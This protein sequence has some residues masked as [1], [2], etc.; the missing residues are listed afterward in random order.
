MRR[1]VLLLA[2][3]SSLAAGSCSAV[4]DRDQLDLCRRVLPALHPNGTELREIRLVPAPPGGVGGIRIDYAAR[5]PGAKTQTH[6]A[7]CRFGTRERGERLDLAAL[8]T[9]NG[10]LGEAR[11][12]FLKRFW[13]NRPDTSSA[14]K[15]GRHVRVAAR[16]LIG[17]CRAARAGCLNEN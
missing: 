1:M 14:N 13:L 10:P 4:M 16:R 17:H 12:L 5:E 8:D 9:D 3:A 11:L 7:V 6:Y 15:P 2:L